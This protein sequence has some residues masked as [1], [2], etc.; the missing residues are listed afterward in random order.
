MRDFRTTLLVPVALTAMLASTPA[1]ARTTI[2]PYLQVEQV[3]SADLSGHQTDDVT[4]TG[5]GAGVDVQFDSNHLHGQ[6]DYQYNHYFSWSKHYGDTDLHQG[7]ARLDYAIAPGLS[8]DASGI[9]TRARGSLNRSSPGLLN[10]DFDNTNQVYGIDVG[11]TYAGHLGDFDI[12]AGYKFGYVKSTDGTGIDLGPGSAVLSNNF[13]DIS[14]TAGASIGQRPGVTLPFGWTVSGG[15]VRDEV[16]FLDARYTGKFGRVD[17]EQPVS[18]TLALLAG[19]GYQADT[20]GQAALLTDANGN[21]ILTSNRHLQADHSKP[22]VLSYDQSGLVWDVGVLWRPSSRTYLKIRG[23]QRYGQTVV[24][25]EF[26]HQ[27]TPTATI[28]VVAYDDITSFGRQLSGGIGGLPTSFSSPITAVPISLSG[29]VFG[30]N[31]G[32]GGCI[33]GLSSVNANFYRS[34]G[35]SGMISVQ[36]GLWTWGLGVNYDNRHYFAPHD[37]SLASTFDGVDENTVTVNGVVQRRLSQVSSITGNIYAAWYDSG[38]ANS[39]H[40]TTYGATASYNRNFSRRL[41]GDASVS[42]YSG[43]GGNI[44]QDVV[45]SAQVGVRYSL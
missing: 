23:G 20:A 11:P 30:A 4:Y 38:L 44:D 24:T 33:P 6:I 25:G 43:S 36:R 41:S 35:V 28:Q 3:F 29:C 10:G 7:L 17:I 42:V 15:F 5:V 16:Q 14:H 12:N 34:R 27:L 37:D 22:R 39:R 32:P 18:P 45:G 19:A 8:L 26:N 21:A 31:G 1:A 9:A 2:T 40:F 13:T